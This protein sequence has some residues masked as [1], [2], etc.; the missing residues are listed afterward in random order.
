MA[1][2]ALA[3]LPA[4][5]GAETTVRLAFAWAGGDQPGTPAPA[6]VQ[7]R[8]L[9]GEVALEVAPAEGE[10]AAP[11]VV[12]RV[13]DAAF[14]GPYARMRLVVGGLALPPGD[15]KAD[16]DLRFAFEIVLRRDRLEPGQEVALTVPVATS[17]RRSAMKP[18]LEMPALV[19]D[20]PGRFFLAQQYMAAYAASPEAVAAS[21]EGFALQRL[22]ARAI[23]DFA[24]AMADLPPGPALIVPSTELRDALELYWGNQP[25]GQAVH[26]AAYADARTLLWAD[27]RLAEEHLQTARRAGPEAVA[28]CDRAR[29]LVGFFADHPPAEAEAAKVDRMFPNPG[30]LAG[31]LEGRRLDIGFVCSRLRI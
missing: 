10:G 29:A 16:Q 6:E 28:W 30:T 17:S 13:P 4:L 22:I 19:E 24:I 11:G 5:A 18:L 26:L 21:P 31:Y 15:S 2:L 8:D 27:L 3:L 12:L 14:R 25:K 1:A 7:A 9:L 23:A 20:L